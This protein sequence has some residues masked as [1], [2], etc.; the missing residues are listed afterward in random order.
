MITNNIT[1]LKN[2][3]NYGTVENLAEK[4]QY[5]TIYCTEEGKPFYEDGD[6]KIESNGAMID[7]IVKSQTY[8]LFVNGSLIKQGGDEISWDLLKPFFDNGGVKHEN[9]LYSFDH[10]ELVETTV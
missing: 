7:I 6:G 10:A 2:I 9:Q 4:Y 8:T 3:L 1:Y 5:I